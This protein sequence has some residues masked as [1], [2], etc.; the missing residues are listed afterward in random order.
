MREVAGSAALLA[1]TIGAAD[2]KLVAHHAYGKNGKVASV[3]GTGQGGENGVQ[4]G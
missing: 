3:P 4:G 2:A 1:E